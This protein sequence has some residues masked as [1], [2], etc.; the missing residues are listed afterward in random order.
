M[1]NSP[2]TGDHSPCSTDHFPVQVN[3]F[4]CWKQTTTLSEEIMF[5]IHKTQT[6]LGF[7]GIFSGNSCEIAEVWQALSLLSASVARHDPP[8]ETQRARRIAHLR[9]NW[10]PLSGRNARWKHNL[11]SQVLEI[12]GQPWDFGDCGAW[13]PS[14]WRN[15]KHASFN[16]T[17]TSMSRIGMQ[18][19]GNMPF[20]GYSWDTLALTA[21][22]HEPSA[23]NRRGSYAR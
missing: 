18:F 17:D 10:A 1:T 12:F 23:A 19:A 8:C 15:G 9:V 2:A 20:E 4:R 22:C 11:P 3:H 5:A 6:T 21:R 13:G 7:G 16:I 14:A